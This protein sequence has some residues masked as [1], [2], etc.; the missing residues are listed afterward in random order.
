MMRFNQVLNHVAMPP[1]IPYRNE[2]I[3]DSMG[4]ENRTLAFHNLTAGYKIRFPLVNLKKGVG[5]N[6]DET[7]VSK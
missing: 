4:Y 5:E 6:T 7:R 3:S 2:I 1:A